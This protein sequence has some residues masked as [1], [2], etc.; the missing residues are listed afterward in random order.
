MAATAEHQAEVHALVRERLKA[1]KPVWDRTINLAGVFHDDALSFIDWR[2]SVVAI[3]RTSSWVQDADQ[4]GDLAQAVDGLARV[5]HL[6]EFNTWWD[7][8]YDLA[9]YDR[10]RITTRPGT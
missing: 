10:V 9:D 5:E 7:M 8:L 1:G 3:L 4:S 6:E 2:D